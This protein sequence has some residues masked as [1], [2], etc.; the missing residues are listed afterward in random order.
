M[1]LWWLSQAL[2]GPFHCPVEG[3]GSV[4]RRGVVVARLLRH[5]EDDC[6]RQ[7]QIIPPALGVCPGR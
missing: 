1:G 2:G 6:L 7:S 5:F 3:L 4:R